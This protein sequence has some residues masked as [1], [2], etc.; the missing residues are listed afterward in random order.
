[1][2]PGLD[3]CPPSEYEADVALEL[4]SFTGTF[5]IPKSK[6]YG[7]CRRIVEFEKKSMLKGTTSWVYRKC[8]DVRK[9]IEVCVKKSKSADKNN[10]EK[11]L[12]ILRREIQIVR[13]LKDQNVMEFYEPAVGETLENVYLIFEC[14]DLFLSDLIEQKVDALFH[15]AVVKNIMMQT[16]RALDYIHKH[17]I[18]HRDLNPKNLM[19][20]KDGILK[21][22][23]FENARELDNPDMK[24]ESTCKNYHA[25]EL[26]LKAATHG[27]AV[28]IWAAGCLICELLLRES[29]IFCGNTYE[30]IYQNIINILGVPNNN[31]WPGYSDLPGLK[32]ME[33]TN[34]HSY[35]CLNIF[36][37]RS[38]PQ[39]TET[40][41]FLKK[42]F[43]YDPSKRITAEKCLQHPFFLEIPSGCPQKEMSK[44]LNEILQRRKAISKTQ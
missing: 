22:A 5:C 7:G 35:N 1:M 38:Y 21:L 13:L 44:V 41:E 20:R 26:I 31:L 42:V 4:K 27:T 43:I 39:S 2:I 34:A 14:C 29:N 9:N 36:F 11:D 8:L 16:F 12:A 18:V 10:I 15:K 32:Q 25:P 33:I 23:N 24:L 3:V 40:I 6:I 37:K 19:F 28:D 30:L 17:H